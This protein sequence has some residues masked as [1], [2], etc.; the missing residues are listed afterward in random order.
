ML[1]Q[2]FLR[3]GSNSIDFI[4]NTL[5]HRK[6]QEILIGKK[7]SSVSKPPVEAPMPTIGKPARMIDVFPV[8]LD[9]GYTPNFNFVISK[10]IRR[11]A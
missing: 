6:D 7:A 11:F 3:V 5:F 10:P 1:L 9:Y 2:L 4:N 8:V